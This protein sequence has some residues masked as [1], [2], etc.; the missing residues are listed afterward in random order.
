[1]NTAKDIMSD[2]IVNADSGR[3]AL[4]KMPRSNNLRIELDCHVL[5]VEDGF[6]NVRFLVRVL[7]KAGAKVEVAVHGQVAMEKVLET[8]SCDARDASSPRPFDLILMDME[9]PIMD[10]Y[11][12]T[13]GLRYS[14]YTGRIIALTGR[15]ESYDRQ[16]CLDAGCDD[17]LAKPFDRTE[18]LQLIRKHVGGPL[19]L[20]E[21]AA[22]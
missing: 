18:L 8:L 7:K 6:A 12:A 9:M 22:G 2:Q 16:K 19:R 3:T 21:A 5:L 1:M 17:Y 14:G 13:R 20:D 11:E 10:G 4:P 15:T